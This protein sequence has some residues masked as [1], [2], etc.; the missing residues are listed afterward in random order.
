[1]CKKGRTQSV[2]AVWSCHVRSST[3]NRDVGTPT[4]FSKSHPLLTEHTAQPQADLRVGAVTIPSLE[5]TRFRPRL[6]PQPQPQPRGDL[7]YLRNAAGVWAPQGLGLL[8]DTALQ[9]HPS[10]LRWNAEAWCPSTH[11]L[12]TAELIPRERG[13]L[14]ATCAAPCV[15]RSSRSKH[16]QSRVS[17]TDSW[18]SGQSE[19]SGHLSKARFTGTAPE[20]SSAHGGTSCCLRPSARLPG[21]APGPLGTAGLHA[22][23]CTAETPPRAGSCGV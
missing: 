8:A 2:Y 13:W 11:R 5:P 12:Y 10:Q 14:G 6:P 15:T 22:V 19:V 3:Y 7:G 4:A 20:P 16:S 9:S 23:P 17:Y 21:S 1:M 18:S